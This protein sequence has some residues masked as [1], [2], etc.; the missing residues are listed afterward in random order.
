[1]SE[2]ISTSAKRIGR[3]SRMLMVSLITAVSCLLLVGPVWAQVVAEPG[4]PP[5]TDP[6]P[7]PVAEPS[8]PPVAEPGPPPVAEPS[9]PPAAGSAPPGADPSRP[10]AAEPE[11]APVSTP[12]P[13]SAPDAEPEQ[14][15]APPATHEAETAPVP[16]SKATPEPVLPGPTPAPILAAAPELSAPKGGLTQPVGSST[17]FRPGTPDGAVF[18][19]ALT[20]LDEPLGAPAVMAILAAGGRGPATVVSTSGPDSDA[21]PADPSPAPSPQPLPLTGGAASGGAGAASSG[22]GPALYALLFVA[23]ALAAGLWSR[24]QLVPARWRSVTIVALNERPG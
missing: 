22:G 9:P 24:L 10:S 20:L 21:A 11:P 16:T 7:P 14:A 12:K 8:I 17:P 5:V 1:L 15:P 2:S 19:D 3:G 6:G 13:L 18:R 4:P 23:A